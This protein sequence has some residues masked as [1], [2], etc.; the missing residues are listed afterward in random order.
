V[1]AVQQEVQ[2]TGDMVSAIE[3]DSPTISGDFTADDANNL[4]VNTRASFSG[5]SAANIFS[6]LPGV[7]ADSSG[8]LIA[9]RAALPGG[10]DRR[11]RYTKT[12]PAATSSPDTF[13]S[14][15]SISEIRADGVLANAELAIP[16][17]SSSPPR[18]ARTLHGSGFWY[19]QDSKW[20]AIPY[21]YPTTT[22]KP[23]VHGATPSAAARAARW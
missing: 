12:R 4:P 20:D 9:G 23:D 8:V 13:P 3:T 10:R 21:T 6:A 7:Q 22:T 17:R 18:A 15:E 11:R 16:A 2:V 14:T 5:T 1:G 19:Y